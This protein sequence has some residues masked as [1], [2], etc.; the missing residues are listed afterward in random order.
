MIGDIWK[1]SINGGAVQTAEALGIS[2]L[3]I[4]FRA[5]G[6]DEASFRVTAATA[7]TADAA[8]AYGD[9]VIITRGPSRF[10]YG[11]V[12]TLPRSGSDSDES[13][14]VRLEGPWW[15]LRTTIFVQ[16]DY[17]LRRSAAGGAKGLVKSSKVQFGGFKTRSAFSGGTWTE[18]P[19]SET[20][21][22]AS[23]VNLVLSYLSDYRNPAAPIAVGTVD[24]GTV[25]IPKS[26]MKDMSCADILTRLLAWVPDTI[27]YF[28]HSTA[29]YPTIHVRKISGLSAHGVAITDRI[30]TA[31]FVPR[32]DIVA[33][34]VVCFFEWDGS[35]GEWF[36]DPLFSR[37]HQQQSYPPGASEHAEGVLSAH[38]DLES[39]PG[40][41][42]QHQ[43]L[44]TE[45]IQ[46]NSATWWQKKIPWLADGRMVSLE[47]HSGSLD[48]SGFNREI[49]G[50]TIT[51]WME[52][53]LGFE[54]NSVVARA[55]IDF[56]WVDGNSVTKKK[57]VALSMT[58]NGSNKAG[59]SFTKKGSGGYS[60]QPPPGLAQRLYEA[61]SVLHWQGNVDFCDRECGSRP[62]PGEILRVTGGRAEWETMTAVVYE[63]YLNI[64][65]GE[66]R[67]STGIPPYLTAGQ[68]V[69][70]WRANR[71]TEKPY[72]GLGSD[73]D[74]SGGDAV[75]GPGKVQNSD[76][77]SG[78]PKILKLQAT[79]SGD[80]NQVTIDGEEGQLYCYQA[81]GGGQPA[82]RVTDLETIVD[83]NLPARSLS[84]TS[85][86]F[87]FEVDGNSEAVRMTGSSGEEFEVNLSLETLK[88][89]GAGGAEVYLDLGVLTSGEK[90]VELVEAVCWK[91][92]EAKKFY[93]A[94][95]ADGHA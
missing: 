77:A 67:I 74:S 73:G 34:G 38:I 75:R 24:I 88:F 4:S 53:D 37:F 15:Y 94:M 47:V 85:G 13:Y 40:T 42:D 52:E 21:D 28:D 70:L 18:G 1:F 2:D 60:E 30:T 17:F 29:P 43:V 49:V 23:G 90:K 7:L 46:V 56:E 66:T 92:G 26:E 80:Q 44:Y 83:I 91:D 6:A 61:M 72:K 86:D 25:N 63:A 51:D 48:P 65:T 95:E 45:N 64:D 89:K 76:G 32:H 59:G 81:T 14:Q 62:M 39:S 36:D 54:A 9:T 87:E 50:G 12:T 8:F 27:V 10:F 78:E 33:A 84:L 22:L 57:N 79:D 5:N 3:R 19:D 20:A 31:G 55:K 41:P 93:I 69:E 68:I 82:L 16:S 11:K 35:T 58:L 71:R